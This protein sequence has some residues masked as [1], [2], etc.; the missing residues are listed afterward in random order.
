MEKDYSI[1]ELHVH[2]SVSIY[3]SIY[4]VKASKLSTLYLFAL[5]VIINVLKIAIFKYM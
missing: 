2:Y 4:F 1:V 3:F 5:Y